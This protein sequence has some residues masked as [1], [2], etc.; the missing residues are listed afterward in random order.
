MLKGLLFFFRFLVFWLVFFFIERFVFL[1]INSKLISELPLKE[2]ASTFYHSL[3]LDLSMAAYITVV[4]LLAFI[5][6]MMTRR[7]NIELKWINYYVNVLVVLF[8][9]ITVCNFNIYREWGSKINAKALEVAINTPNE[10]M[11]SSASSPI[12]LSIFILLVLIVLGILLQRYLVIK[13]LSFSKLSIWLKI[14]IALLILGLNFLVIRGGKSGSPINQSMA[15]FSKNQ[16]LNLAAVNTEWNLMSSLIAA[17]KTKANPYVYENT[18]AANKLINELY[19]VEKDSTTLVL[20]TERPNIVLFIMESFTADL[21]ATLG[22]TEGITPGFDSLTHEGI[23]F[24]NIYS[25]GNRTDKGFIGT[26]AGF[27]TL[28][29][30]NIVKWPEKT[31][32]LPS[33]SRSLNKVGY[34]N[35]FF[36]GGESEFDNYKAFLLSHD[37]H[38]LVDKNNFE[39]GTV[40]SWG[41][42][43]GAVF[44]RQLK[45]IQTAKQPFFSTILTLTNHE[46]FAVPGKSKFGTANNVSKFKSTAYYTDSCIVSYLREAKK[47]PWYKNTL[48][49]FIADHG[50]IYPKN[51][52]DIFIPER[53]HI[54]FLMYGDVIKP[55]FRG[56]AFEGTGSQADV[57]A[58]LLAQLNLN[59]KDFK[60]SKNLLNPYVKP[61]AF[62]S[63]DNGMGFIDKQQCVTFDNIGKVILYNSRKG[64]S[65]S[66]ANKLQSAKA[67]LQVVYEDF[68][69]L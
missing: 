1:I 29:A 31:Q 46:P 54:P 38:Q 60:W 57:A 25:T 8:S 48:F 13:R 2:V 12:G 44:Q 26:L 33:I 34:H 22:K 14:P 30:V 52:T 47:Q 15:Y 62:F 32:K 58:T 36:Y 68:L 42:F 28:A 56:K 5:I 69:K 16:V 51:R 40:T 24:S 6:A 35:S 49:L 11:A 19:E 10:A 55:E 66:T 3:L 41:Q 7:K 45:D 37:V 23:L 50:H 61:F 65:L 39:G 9:I 4:P 64:D 67:Y 17:N 59:T 63:W 27:P 43:D 53:Y 20:T 21:T 18:L